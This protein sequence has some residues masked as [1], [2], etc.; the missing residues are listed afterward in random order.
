VDTGARL[1]LQTTSA[2]PKPKGEGAIQDGCGTRNKAEAIVA[3]LVLDTCELV[4]CH[5]TVI[6]GFVAEYAYTKVLSSQYFFPHDWGGDGTRENFVLA[7]VCLCS[8]S[9]GVT[10]HYIAPNLCSKVG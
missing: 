1:Y 6:F 2:V 3:S 9:L 8:G 4:M 7:K 5:M 10:G